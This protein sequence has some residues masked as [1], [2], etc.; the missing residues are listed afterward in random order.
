MK[1]N[2][3]VIFKKHSHYKKLFWY[4]E[5]RSEKLNNP[6]RLSKRDPDVETGN[7]IILFTN[8]HYKVVDKK[9]A[10]QNECLKNMRYFF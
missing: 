4:L 6:E 9:R 8:F 5:L 7:K 1:L 10:L 2:Q 3:L